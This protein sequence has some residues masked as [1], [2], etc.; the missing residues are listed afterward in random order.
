MAKGHIL[1]QFHIANWKYSSPNRKRK[2]IY[3]CS[4]TGLINGW[5]IDTIGWCTFYMQ[6][7]QVQIQIESV[8]VFSTDGEC[9]TER[10]LWGRHWD[11]PQPTLHGILRCWLCALSGQLGMLWHP[12]TKLNRGGW[13]PRS[14]LWSFG[15]F[16]GSRPVFGSHHM[17]YASVWLPWLHC[18]LIAV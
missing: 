9:S 10:R 18:L 11:W 5:S 17:A 15:D 2:L 7:P 16:G 3:L 1:Q 6:K 12:A 14:K 8:G 13:V 4:F